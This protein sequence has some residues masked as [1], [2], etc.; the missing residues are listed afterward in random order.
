MEITG[1]E[2]PK[3]NRIR[4]WRKF[5]S[6]SQEGLGRKLGLNSRVIISHW[7]NG[8]SHPNPQQISELMEILECKFEDL[9]PDQ[10]KKAKEKHPHHEEE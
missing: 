6:L 9:F 10:V 2:F 5:Q 4:K 8:K 3:S 7:E 1:R